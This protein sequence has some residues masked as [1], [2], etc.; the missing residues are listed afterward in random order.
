[1]SQHDPH[2]QGFQ[3]SDFSSLL[4]TMD[5]WIES[6]NESPSSWE[7]KIDAVSHSVSEKQA[8]G[9]IVYHYE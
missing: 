4:I 5:K 2:I 1:M 6:E 9:I 7:L 8:S 3:S